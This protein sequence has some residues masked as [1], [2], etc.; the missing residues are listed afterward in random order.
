[1]LIVPP[2]PHNEMD[3]IVSLSDFDLDYSD[4]QEKFKD[5]TKLAAYVAGTEVSFVNLID[6]FT[7]WTVGNFGDANGTYPREDTVCQYTI[8]AEEQ[9]EVKD[10][11]L[12]E[13]FKDKEYVTGAPHYRYY[14]G[15]PLRTNDGYNLGALCV[16]DKVGKEISPEKVEL[17]KG[18]ASEILNRMV[19][20]KVIEGLTDK[21]SQAKEAHKKVAHDIR[22]PLGGIISLARVISEQGEDNK[23]DEVLEFI[24]L[25]QKSGNSLLELA[26][27]ILEVET[28]ANK[29]TPNLQANELNLST[30][31]NKLEQLYAL[32]AKNKNIEFVVNANT[33]AQET[34]FSKN[35]L[36]QITGN[37]ISNALKFT[38]QNGKV[39]VELD[40]LTGAQENTL[41][42]VVKDTGV[43]M[44]TEA[45]K[46]IL[47]GSAST[48]KGTNKEKGYGFGLALVKHLT[49]SLK[50]KMDIQSIPG[51][52]ALFDIRLPQRSLKSA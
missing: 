42:V 19:A 12:D 31:K 47:N 4:L 36:L 43:G 17:L 27:E 10:L 16:L 26:E 18:I 6:S 34:P 2:I 11:S 21:V 5:L 49:E 29:G 37:L 9:F 52:G 50:G 20:I 38:A 46:A 15:V 23:L 13:R 51:E 32:Q 24:N 48:T 7:Q 41:H 40:L 33:K 39:T 45:I 28:Q 25:I 8:V 30:F 14:F 22:G 44:D 35:K 1:M 3:R